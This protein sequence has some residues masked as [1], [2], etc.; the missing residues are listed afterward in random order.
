MKS[1]VCLAN[2][3]RGSVV[4]HFEATLHAPSVPGIGETLHLGRKMRPSAS[5]RLEIGRHVDG[6]I[7]SSLFVW[8][9]SLNMVSPSMVHLFNRRLLENGLTYHPVSLSWWGSPRNYIHVAERW[10]M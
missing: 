1:E 2:P 8:V 7:G 6:N 3:Q 10:D 5:T 4:N 9:P